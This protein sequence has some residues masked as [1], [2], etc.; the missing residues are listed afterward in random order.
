MIDDTI[1][2]RAFTEHWILLTNDKDFGEKVY[3]N[4]MGIE[5]SYSSAS[6]TNGLSTRLRRSGA[7]SQST[8]NNWPTV[9]WWSQR[10]GCVLRGHSRFLS[11]CIPYSLADG[12]QV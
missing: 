3:V 2:H 9:L 6:Q 5:A 11:Y 10:H 12:A 1:I 4:A 8:Q 7:C